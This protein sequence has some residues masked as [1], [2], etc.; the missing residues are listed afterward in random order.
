MIFVVFV[1]ISQWIFGSHDA[2]LKVEQGSSSESNSV[3]A[4]PSPPGSNE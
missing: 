3:T 4:Q 1:L 2:P